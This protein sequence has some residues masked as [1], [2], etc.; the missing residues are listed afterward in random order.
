MMAR[1]RVQCNV[2]LNCNFHYTGL[3]LSYIK[4]VANFPDT[5]YYS[6]SDNGSEPT[7]VTCRTSLEFSIRQSSACTSSSQGTKTFIVQENSTKSYRR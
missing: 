7:R 6:A 2:K 1:Y 4:S 5:M 3:H